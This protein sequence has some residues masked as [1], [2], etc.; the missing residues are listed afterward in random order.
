MEMIPRQS[1]VGEC[2]KV[3]SIPLSSTSAVSFWNDRSVLPIVTPAALLR[4]PWPF[5]HPDFIYEVKY[6]GFRALAYW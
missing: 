1:L 2:S 5:D 3:N 6:D 4:I